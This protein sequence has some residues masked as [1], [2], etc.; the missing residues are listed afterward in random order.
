MK[1]ALH[2]TYKRAVVT[3]VCGATFETR[4]S[5]GNLHIEICSAC[6]PYYTGKQKLLDSAGRVERFKRKYAGKT[7]APAVEP[8]TPQA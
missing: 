2:P 1:K 4:S 8:S 6:H 3:C 5:V 7:Q